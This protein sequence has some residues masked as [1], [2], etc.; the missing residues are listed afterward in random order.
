MNIEEHPVV[1]SLQSLKEFNDESAKDM[2]ECGRAV[3]TDPN[4]MFWRRVSIRT[5]AAHVEG[6]IYLMK[7][8]ILQM[9]PVM[10]VHFHEG[11]IAFLKEVSFELNGKGEVMAKPRFPR[12]IDNFKFVCSSF[13][14][15][16]HS[17]FKIKYEDDGFCCFK[18]AIKIRDRLMHPKSKSDLNISDD[19]FKTARKAWDW[20]QHQFMLMGIDCMSSST[21]YTNSLVEKF[22]GKT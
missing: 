2:A 13:A 21:A 17:S 10:K 18:D 19:E 3:H 22:K 11:E 14:R 5:F 16:H 8:S 15:V 7:Q 4:S 1:K 9:Y 20:H 6:L 12:F